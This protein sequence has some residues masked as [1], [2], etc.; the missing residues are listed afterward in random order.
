[1]FGGEVVEGQQF[2]DVVNPSTASWLWAG[3]NE[4]ILPEMSRDSQGFLTAAD[5]QWAAAATGVCC[6]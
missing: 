3:A 1:V 4:S 2:V 5:A 6:G